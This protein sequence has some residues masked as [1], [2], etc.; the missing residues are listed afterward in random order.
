VW[1]LAEQEILTTA[2]LSK[3]VDDGDIT[4]D[5]EKQFKAVINATKGKAPAKG[6]NLYKVSI[7]EFSWKSLPGGSISIPKPPK[8]N[9]EK[10]RFVAPKITPP[11]LKQR[12][13]SSGIN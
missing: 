10:A 9:L 6:K 3:W 13:F 2:V 12:L 11:R 4:E 1:Y 5:Q 8:V 7:P